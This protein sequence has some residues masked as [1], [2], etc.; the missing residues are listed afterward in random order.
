MRHLYRQ[1]G[2]TVLEEIYI[3]LY[4]SDDDVQ[5][6]V[7]RIYQA[8]A[9]VVF[10]TVVGTGTAEL[11]RAIARRYGD[12]RRPPI[13]SLTTSEAEVA[14]MESDVAEGQVVVA[15]YFSSIDTSASRAF[16]QACH[17]FFPENATIT[18]WA[19]AA[20]WQTL[21]LGRAAQAA[22]SWRVEDVQ[23][24][25]YDIDIDAPQ[26]PVRVERQNNHSR[27]SSRIAEIDARGVF[28][29]RWQSPEPIRP[30][31]YVVVHNLDDWSA[32]MG[33]GALP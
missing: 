14:K 23:R 26:G 33:G 29:V 3:P 1:H 7:E 24:H 2:G 9:D 32:S 19:E 28:Q 8:R 17:G 18:A 12:G 5:R 16:V 30:D 13:A 4:P 25:L 27:L 20:Y 21:L 31:P 15:P 11:Y 6:A 22:G 10:S